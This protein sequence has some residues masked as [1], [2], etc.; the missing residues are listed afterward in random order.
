MK[1]IKKAMIA[2][3]ALGFLQLN[4]TANADERGKRAFIGTALGIGLGAGIGGAIG[5]GEGAA[6][7]AVTGA[8]VGA[9]AGAA[10]ADDSYMYNLNARLDDLYR[11]RNHLENKLNRT[12][13]DR[14]AQQ[15]QNQIDDIDSE[16]D[17]IKAELGR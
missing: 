2:L 4:Q 3:V 10:A 1:H 17:D 13:S 5:G 9:T 16:I 15:I 6:I 12:D 11:E 14:K 7:G 8:A